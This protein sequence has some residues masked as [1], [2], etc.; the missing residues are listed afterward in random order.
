MLTSGLQSHITSCTWAQIEAL[1]YPTSGQRRNCGHQSGSCIKLRNSLW[2]TWET[3]LTVWLYQ[4]LAC[5]RYSIWWSCARSRKTIRKLSE[6][7]WVYAIPQSDHK[8]EAY[9]KTE[10][11]QQTFLDYRVR[12][13]Q[14][15]RSKFWRQCISHRTWNRINQALLCRGCRCIGYCETS[16]MFSLTY[17][18]SAIWR[19][20]VPKHSLLVWTE[21]LISVSGWRDFVDLL[22]IWSVFQIVRI[23]MCSEV[24]LH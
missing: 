2:N 9:C 3:N 24:F 17:A 6:R 4:G 20:Q 5:Y 16:A 13:I 18:S 10:L 21:L 14:T 1:S 11:T 22:H 19:W 23:P 12:Q 8:L 7:I 15:S